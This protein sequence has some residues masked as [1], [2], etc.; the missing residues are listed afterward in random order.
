MNIALSCRARRT[1]L[2][3]SLAT[4]IACGCGMAAEPEA[5]PLPQEVERIVEQLRRLP[6]GALSQQLPQLLARYPEY[7]RPMLQA[8]KEDGSVERIA[9][10]DD[11]AGPEAEE[12]ETDES[13][14]EPSLEPVKVKGNMSGVAVAGGVLGVGALAAAAGGGGGGSSSSAPPPPAPPPPPPSDPPSSF[15][16]DEFNR[17]WGLGRIK[18]Q[19]AYSRGA[20][21]QGIIVGV[22]DGG[23]EISHPEFSGRIAPGGDVVRPGGPAMTDLDGHGTHVAGIIAANRNG[24]G[25]HGVA[26][27]A[28]VLPIKWISAEDEDEETIGTYNEMLDR[29]VQLGARI[30]NNSWGFRTIPDPDDEDSYH[31]TR[32]QDVNTADYQGIAN[33]YRQAQQAGLVFVFSVGNNTTGDASLGLEPGVLAALPQ[34]FSQLQGQWLAVVNITEAGTIANSSHRCGAA[35]AWC[36]AAPGTRITGPHLDGTYATLTGTSMSAPHVSGGLALLMQLFPTLSP[37]Q[38]VER[39]LVSADRT[40]I[41]ADSSVYGRGLLDLEAASRPIGSV[42]ATS[43]SGQVTSVGGQWH[44]GGATGDALRA[45]LSQI[46]VVLKDSLDAPFVYA[47]D[48]VVLGERVGHADLRR[49]DFLGRLQDE[50]YGHR[51]QLANGTR[52]QY[53]A[54]SDHRGRHAL[55]QAMV[56]R[57]LLSGADLSL[58]LNVDPSWSQ[59]LLAFDPSLRDVGVLSGFGNPFLSLHEGA[60]GVGWAQAPGRFGRW[61]LQVASGEAGSARRDGWAP[62][63]RQDSLQAEWSLQGRAGWRLGLQAGVLEEQRRMLGAEADAWS[64]GGTRTFFSG[65]DLVVPLGR[66][67]QGLAR[68]HVGNSRLDGA[69]WSG[70]GRMYSDGGLLGLLFRPASDW[71]IGA[72][73]HQ[74]LAVRQ[75]ELR[76]SLP[77]RLHADNSVGWEAVQVAFGQER[78]PMEYELFLGYRPEWRRYRLKASVIH[79]RH[80]LDAPGPRDSVLMLHASWR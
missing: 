58:G 50:A 24:V 19:H 52:L 11:I 55:G 22:V 28:Q 4:A 77:T 37:R 74:P 33:L 14:R 60:V 39:V 67:V 16:T 72:L 23:V 9:L 12:A 32:L 29:Q 35:A 43:P 76:L 17:N 71:R 75:A 41:Y 45:A 57:T 21:G 56:E 66:H 31:S 44:V 13:D 47:A 1:R 48:A 70:T 59:G 8:L 18:A 15:E 2:A 20:T 7:R 64:R 6:D 49:I 54:A 69:D 65:I 79:L 80:P 61:R 68:Y 73:A 63:A 34:A 36:L 78:R 25:T 5:G 46:D 40:G 10:I 27:L 51:A 3:V 53:R 42:S 26:P 30:S 38:I 62:D